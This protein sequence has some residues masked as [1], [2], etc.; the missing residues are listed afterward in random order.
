[1]RF[2]SGKVTFFDRHKEYGFLTGEE[3]GH[4][5]FR[6]KAGRMVAESAL[7]DEPALSLDYRIKRGAAVKLVER[8]KRGDELYFVRAGGQ[9]EPCAKIWCFAIRYRYMEEKI[10]RRKAAEMGGEK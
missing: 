10:R 7:F 9:S 6:Y 8:P 2:E 3:G 5:Y 4:V 1:M